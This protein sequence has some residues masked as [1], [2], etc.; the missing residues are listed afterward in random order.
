MFCLKPPMNMLPREEF[1][2][3]GDCSPRLLSH[4]KSTVTTCQACPRIKIRIEDHEQGTGTE[5]IS[6]STI[7]VSRATALQ[8]ATLTPAPV[9]T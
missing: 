7:R 1:E 5:Y 2:C 6:Q 4:L 8:R 9:R 3:D